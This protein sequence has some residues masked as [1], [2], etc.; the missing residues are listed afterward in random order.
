MFTHEPTATD[1]DEL[2]PEAQLKRIFGN[3]APITIYRWRRDDP[4][5]PAPDFIQN[6]RRFYTR[7][8][9]RAYRQRKL[10]AAA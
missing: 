1:D 10:E 5:F 2:L 7:R 8:K 3:V 9:I 6:G 4:D